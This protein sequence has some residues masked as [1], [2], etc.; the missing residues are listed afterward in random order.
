MRSFLLSVLYALLLL[1]TVSSAWSFGSFG[2]FLGGGESLEKRADN[3]DPSAGSTAQT[4]T[5]PQTSTT[6]NTNTNTNTNTASDSTSTNTKTDTS[7]K[8]ETTTTSI[9]INPA[10]AAGGISM[11]TPASSSTTYYRIGQNVTFVWNYTSLS[12]TPSYVNVV[13]SCSLNSETYTIS[14]NM[15]VKPTGSVVWDTDA[16]MTVPLLT[17]TYTLYVYDASKS[18]GDIPSAGHLSSLV[19]YDF[20]MYIKLPYTPLGQ[21]KCATCN[22]ALS[23]IQRMGLKFTFGMAAITVASFTWFAGGFGAFAT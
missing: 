5:A 18:L 23:D 11:I 4:S 15:S 12:V 7:T 13:A 2:G 19:G 20:G 21:F 1:G 16:T 8:S 9:S 17:A 22:S 14:S 3:S 6:T 10:A